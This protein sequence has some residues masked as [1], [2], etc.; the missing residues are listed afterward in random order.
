ML[1]NVDLI[2]FYKGVQNCAELLKSCEESAVKVW[3]KCEFR[4]T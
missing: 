1:T 4:W 2:T 3:R